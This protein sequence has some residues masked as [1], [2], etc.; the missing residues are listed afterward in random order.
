M[1]S[2]LIRNIESEEVRNKLEAI[3]EDE[4]FGEWSTEA[5]LIFIKGVLIDYGTQKTTNILKYN[6]FERAVYDIIEPY[7]I[8]DEDN[9]KG[10]KEERSN[11]EFLIEEKEHLD[12]KIREVQL[13]LEGV[14]RFETPYF[15][16]VNNLEIDLKM[17][18]KAMMKYSQILQK[19]INRL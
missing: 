11:R 9:I 16:T 18:F 15:V 12:I 3:L 14:T 5:K 1:K 10:N 13:E 19:R 8:R 2:K 6:D 7:Y 4:N 17:Q